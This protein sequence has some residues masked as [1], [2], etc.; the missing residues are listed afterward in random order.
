MDFVFSTQRGDTSL[1]NTKIIAVLG[2]MLVLSAMQ[3]FGFVT[4]T[5]GQVT[6]IVFSNHVLPTDSD[7][8]AGGA[9]GGYHSDQGPINSNNSCGCTY[10]GPPNLTPGFIPKR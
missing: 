6:N 4:A 9:E 10:Q 3:G 2:I 8:S 1:I 7:N 5:H